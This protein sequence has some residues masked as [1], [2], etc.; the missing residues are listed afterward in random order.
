[1]SK[2]DQK[3]EAIARLQK[4]LK[5][6]DTLYTILRH[7]IRSGMSRNISVV[8]VKNGDAWEISYLVAQALD[9]SRAKDGGIICKGCGM[10]MG[11]NLVCSLSA[12][13]FS[14]KG[15]AS[16]QLQHRWI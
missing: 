8:R 6:G 7:K 11:F 5:I 1:M 3:N 13:L 2:S 10:D 16:D 12:V 15:R 9:R 4:E 14:D